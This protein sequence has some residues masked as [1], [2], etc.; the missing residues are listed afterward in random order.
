MRTTDT[1]IEETREIKKGL[2]ESNQTP[3][4]KLTIEDIEDYKLRKIIEE[5]NQYKGHLYFTQNYIAFT[6]TTKIREEQTNV[7]IS[8]TKNKD[9]TFKISM[10]AIG[11]LEVGFGLMIPDT[12][13]PDLIFLREINNYNPIPK[14]YEQLSLF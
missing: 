14:K 6:Y 2:K 9:Y 8:I 1:Q 5:L 11:T 10:E 3:S 7:S 4:T 13:A 12:Q